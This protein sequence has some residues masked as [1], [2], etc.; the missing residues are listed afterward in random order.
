MFGLLRARLS[1][2]R[3]HLSRPLQKISDNIQMTQW[4]M[5]GIGKRDVVDS[6]VSCMA[7]INDEI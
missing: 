7:M 6:H 2:Q 3:G 5:D 1:Q 4:F